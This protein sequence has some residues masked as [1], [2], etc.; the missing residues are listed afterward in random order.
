MRNYAEVSKHSEQRLNIDRE[1]FFL[2]YSPRQ[3]NFRGFLILV[4]ECS[5]YFLQLKE[6]LPNGFDRSKRKN[7]SDIVIYLGFSGAII[8]SNCDITSSRRGRS[9]PQLSEKL[10]HWLRRGSINSLSHEYD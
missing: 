8:W 5:K 3:L 2:D 9:F 1:V 4:V 6:I 10:L 7:S